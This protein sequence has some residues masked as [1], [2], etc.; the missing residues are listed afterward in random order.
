MLLRELAVEHRRG[1]RSAA[2]E[3][4]ET[5]FVIG[6]N[7]CGLST[8]LDGLELALTAAPGE[9]VPASE[10]HRGS[11]GAPP[12]AMR[13]A[14]TFEERRTGEW[15]SAEHAPLARFLGSAGGRRRRL[16]LEARAEP[17]SKRRDSELALRVLGERNASR[18]P[19]LVAH[20]RRMNPL[21][22]V[23]GGSIS[24]HG[25]RAE[26]PRAP[27]GGRVAHELAALAERVLAAA[28]ELLGGR[29]IDP[30]ARLRDGFEAATELVGARPEHVDPSTAGLAR[31]VLEILDC[32]GELHRS[33]REARAGDSIA[34]QLGVLLLVA[35]VL[36]ALPDGLPPGAEPLWVLETP[37]ANLHPMTLAAVGHLLERIRWQK[38]VTTHSPDLLARAPL[39]Q[40]RRLVRH[41]GEL[42]A[43][44]VR[45]GRLASDDLRRVAHHLR[46][47]RSVAM[48]ARAWL[49]V[50]GESEFWILPQ[51]A[52]V[53]GHDFAVA[54]VACVEYAQ[55]GLE[56]LL[57]AARELGIEWHVLADGDEAGQGYAAVARR[58]ARRGEGRERV[59]LLA[60]RD[61]EHCLWANGYADVLRE[62]AGISSRTRGRVPASRAIQ[63]AIKRHS[64]PGLALLLLEAIAERGPDGVPAPLRRVVETSLELARTAPARLAREAVRATRPRSNPQ[65][66]V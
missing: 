44:S 30:S 8:L 58:H 7:D 62:A 55:A 10:F 25:P 14:L 22:R 66:R 24:G 17:S 1:L 53:L 57:R 38:I 5:C 29:S 41:E 47:R 23:S 64:K 13:V 31:T 37:E 46:A 35:A 43:R 11:S 42:V 28:D 65:G 6:E 12:V 36:R 16:V 20:V 61:I 50:E 45:K 26:S 3:L 59:T 63:S 33:E 52:Q 60:E 51:L 40:I 21:V 15:S 9:R 2:L 18:D 19:E 27:R 56:P 48:F 39:G 32:D 34:E 4:G 49:F 54:G